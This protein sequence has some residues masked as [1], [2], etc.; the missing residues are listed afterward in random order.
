MRRGIMRNL[1]YK[2]SLLVLFIIFV[3][4]ASLV[5]AGQS[6]QKPGPKET[7]S[8]ADAEK[9]AAAQTALNQIVEKIVAKET[10]LGATMKGMHPLVE[11]YI[12]NLD[13]DDAL[14]FHPTGDQ[15]FLGKLQFNPGSIHE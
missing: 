13:K 3:T 6:Q 5:F 2:P 10:A 8:A 4:G 12:Q 15:Y 11:T 9:N 1:N 14:A 7:A